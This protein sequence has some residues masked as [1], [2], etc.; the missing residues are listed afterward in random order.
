MLLQPQSSRP[1]EGGQK[2]PTV[3]RRCD[4]PSSRRPTVGFFGDLTVDPF[5]APPDPAPQ[6]VSARSEKL[7]VMTLALG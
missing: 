6:A 1:S 4:L 7:R 2:K 3:G 5:L